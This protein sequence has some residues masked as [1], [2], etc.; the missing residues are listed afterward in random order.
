MATSI[1]VINSTTT[2]VSDVQGQQI[3]AAINLVLPQFCLDWSLPTCVIKYIPKGQPSNSGNIK[4]KLFLLDNNPPNQD[5]LAYHNIVADVPYSNIFC[6]IILS[7]PGTVLYSNKINVPTI[8]QAV[9]HEIFEMLVDPTCNLWADNGASTLNK[10]KVYAYEVCD[11][12]ESNMNQVSLP[13]ASGALVWN[14]TSG[15]FQ[16]I[17]VPS[18]QVTLSDWVLPAWFDP[19]RT[20]RPFNRMNTLTKP[21][22]LSPLGYAIVLNTSSVTQLTAMEIGSGVTQS[23]KEKYS[24]KSRVIKHFKR[25]T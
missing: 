14:R 3:V 16:T 2:S 1:V 4:L 18:V 5:T 23:L 17:S 15:V 19:E 10:F 6:K 8:A 25:M 11:P 24:S 7:C 9:S 22:T 20:A 12:V 21:L 13:N